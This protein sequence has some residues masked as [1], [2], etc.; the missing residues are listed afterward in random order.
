VSQAWV[1]HCF[2]WAEARLDLYL[3]W[4]L[5]AHS[6][7]GA[8]SYLGMC[9]WCGLA[10]CTWSI[11]QSFDIFLYFYQLQLCELWQICPLHCCYAG[12]GM[13][14]QCLHSDSGWGNTNS[15]YQNNCCSVSLHSSAMGAVVMAHSTRPHLFHS[16]TWLADLYCPLFD[17][18]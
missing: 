11:G 9:T 18:S 7:S 10:F 15:G 13:G 5:C 17:L 12:G 1:L 6:N 4:W 2:H 14:M 3:Q 16:I 8:V